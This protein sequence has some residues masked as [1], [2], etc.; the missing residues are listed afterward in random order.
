MP[1]NPPVMTFSELERLV[2]SGESAD[3]EFKKTTGLLEKAMKTVCG[4]LNHRGG[5]V[6]FGVS[7][8]GH[9]RG[10][11][12]AEKTRRS[13]S[14]TL[15]RISPAVL[16]EP[17]YVEVQQ[18]EYVVVLR[19]PPGTRRPYMYDGRAYIRNGPMTSELGREQMLEMLQNREK[20][21]LWEAQP[22]IGVALE[23]LDY[24]ELTVTVEEA[25]RR[26]RLNDPATRVPRELLRGL[27]LLHDGRPVNAAVVL[28]AKERALLPN[29]PHCTLRLARFRGTTKQEF[30]D[31]RVAS[32][33]LFELL[34]QGQAFLRRHLPVAGRVVPGV[35]EREDEPIY[36]LE[37]LR[38]ALANALCHRDY[39]ERGGSASIAVFD[40]RLEIGNPGKLPPALTLEALHRAHESIPR[41]P[42]IAR[43]LHWRGIIET[44]GRGTTQILELSARAGLEQPIFSEDGGG[45]SVEFRS[46]TYVAPRT[47]IQDL[48]KIERQLLEIL[49]DSGRLGVK[50]IVQLVELP[51]RTAQDTLKRLQQMHLADF[52]G[53]GRGAKWF[54]V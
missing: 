17:E 32:G 14:E 37:A 7:D 22:A 49:A 1:T 30:E 34:Q 46:T 39:T 47:V 29:Y 51:R 35:I 20:T 16:I 9:I 44:W 3:L 4:M 31:Q 6:L 10:Q 27:G 36:P 11:P 52:A 19:V 40:D 15:K 8:K 2:R 12:V 23:D 50:E 33:N 41:N 18:E 54:K 13:I 38:E 43:I 25:I 48:S 45:F 53:R 26:G 5:T 21:P 28:F 24:Q 42:L